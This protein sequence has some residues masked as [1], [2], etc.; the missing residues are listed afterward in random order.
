MP[1]SA[2]IM[3]YNQFESGVYN[4]IKGEALVSV[5]F[6]VDSHGNADCS[7]QQCRFYQPNSRKCALTGEISEY[8][9]KYVGSH[10]P[11]QWDDGEK[12]ESEDK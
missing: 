8:P 1:K 4:Y 12:I 6:P 5:F 9:S 10:C 11:L 3:A 7:C 2:N